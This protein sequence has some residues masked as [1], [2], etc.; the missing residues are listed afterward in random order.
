M[1]P[2]GAAPAIRKS[3]NAVSFFKLSTFNGGSTWFIGDYDGLM[4]REYECTWE[5]KPPAAGNAGMRIIVTN[6]RRTVWESDNEHWRPLN[7]VASFVFDTS[8]VASNTTSLLPVPIP[9]LIQMPLKDW[10]STPGC[11]IRTQIRCHRSSAGNTQAYNVFLELPNT[12]KFLVA[13]SEQIL[14]PTLY[15]TGT[16]CNISQTIASGAGDNEPYCGSTTYSP[17][18]NLSSVEEGMIKPIL[19]IKTGTTNGSETIYVRS[20]KITVEM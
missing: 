5:T 7:G 16:M 18:F 15:L 20:L 3:P 17:Q 11:F 1:F 9:N 10:L 4:G 12:G 19:K 13:K 8:D 14:N 2:S 6:L